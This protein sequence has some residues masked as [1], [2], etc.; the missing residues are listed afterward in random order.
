VEINADNL[1]S[2]LNEAKRS[3]AQAIADLEVV[4]KR[5]GT[6]FEQPTDVAEAVR[7]GHQLKNRAQVLLLLGELS[8]PLRSDE[9]EPADSEPEPKNGTNS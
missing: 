7:L 5:L 1:D 4:S 3:L 2:A 6:P 9:P 8:K